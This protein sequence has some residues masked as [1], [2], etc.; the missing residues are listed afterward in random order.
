[1]FR[2]NG[3]MTC[4]RTLC[5]GGCTLL[6]VAEHGLI[7]MALCNFVCLLVDGCVYCLSLIFDIII[8]VQM[9]TM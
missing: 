6:F 5:V 8:M 9:L 7:G 2:L 1:M 4:T 3:V